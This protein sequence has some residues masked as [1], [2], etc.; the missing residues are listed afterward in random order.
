MIDQGAIT[1]AQNDD[2]F[3]DIAWLTFYLCLPGGCTRETFPELAAMGVFNLNHPESGFMYA[4]LEVSLNRKEIEAKV[5]AVMQIA[6]R[7]D[8]EVDCVDLDSDPVPT[9]SKFYELWKM[10]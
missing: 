8:L 6:E 7:Y 2:R 5:S 9:K 1:N 10:P 3:E 4:K